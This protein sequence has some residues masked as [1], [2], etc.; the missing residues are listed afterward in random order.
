M[1]GVPT[2]SVYYKSPVTFF[3]ATSKPDECRAFYQDALGL[4]LT[5]EDE[6]AL[7]FMLH[8]ETELRISKVESFTPHSFTVLD[9]QVLELQTAMDKLKAAGI[10]F[11][12]YAFMEQNEDGVWAA[13]DGTQI[14]WFKDPDSNVLSVS[15][16]A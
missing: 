6:Y 5:D 12:T 10:D 16:R 1:K 7:V 15:Q 3:L 2:A 11:L 14:A 9:W 4:S 8:N 13:P